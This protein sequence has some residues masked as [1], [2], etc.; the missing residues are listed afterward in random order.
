M[1]NKLIALFVQMDKIPTLE[2][3]L[4]ITDINPKLQT[5]IFPKV[6]LSNVNGQLV[7]SNIVNQIT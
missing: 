7:F 1:T 2:S 6:L 3:M 5:F 4:L